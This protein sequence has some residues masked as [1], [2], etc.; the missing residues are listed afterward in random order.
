MSRYIS[1]RFMKGKRFLKMAP[2]NLG[3]SKSADPG[4]QMEEN[5]VRR[6]QSPFRRRNFNQWREEKCP[7][8][9]PSHPN[10]LFWIPPS[11]VYTHENQ[12]FGKWTAP[13]PP[14]HRWS[15]KYEWTVTSFMGSL[16][17]KIILGGHILKWKYS[18][19]L[20]SFNFHCM[21]KSHTP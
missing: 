8:T 7:G 16:G 14:T 17:R 10:S 20:T 1:E 9:W 11:T 4:N 18:K 21:K 12:G 6:P 19:N 3:T 5:N 15:T 2:N 13:P